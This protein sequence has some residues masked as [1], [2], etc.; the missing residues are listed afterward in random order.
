[1]LAD[2]SKKIAAAG[3]N[4]KFR[5]IE[6]NGRKEVKVEG[7]IQK[8][9]LSPEILTSVNVD[10][11]CVGIFAATDHGLG[12]DETFDQMVMRLSLIHI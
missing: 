9:H 6:V 2:K 3:L 7:D 1:M 8:E 5:V 11:I 4:Q 10:N 12:V